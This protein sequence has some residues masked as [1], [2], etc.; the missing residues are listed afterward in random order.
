MNK[1]IDSNI[2][3][4]TTTTKKRIVEAFERLTIMFQLTNSLF[5]KCKKLNSFEEKL[6]IV[7]A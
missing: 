6:V 4:F 3:L 5:H 1:P 7:M 2:K